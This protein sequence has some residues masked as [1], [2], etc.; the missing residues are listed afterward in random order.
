MALTAT[1]KRIVALEM[2]QNVAD[3]KTGVD[4]LNTMISTWDLRG[5]DGDLPADVD[6]KQA[7]T[8]YDAISKPVM[9]ISNDLAEVRAVV[10]P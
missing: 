6:V 4:A 1:Q 8:A 5:I 3:L 10:I 2:E 7:L 9:G